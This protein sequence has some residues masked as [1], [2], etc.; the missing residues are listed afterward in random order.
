MLKIIRRKKRK[1]RKKRRRKRF[2]MRMTKSGL[3]M[4]SPYYYHGDMLIIEDQKER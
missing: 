3:Q 4:K 2:Q 1:K